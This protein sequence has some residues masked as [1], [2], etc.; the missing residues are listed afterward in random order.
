M[1]REFPRKVR[2]AESIKRLLAEPIAQVGRDA[3][4]GML[5]VTDVDVASDLSNAT[6][7]VS[8]FGAQVSNERILDALRDLRGDMRQRIARE[9]RMKKIPT[10]HFAVDE[11][12]ATG[13]RISELLAKRP[14]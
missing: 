9:L 6:V 11:S 14:D 3:G 1:P 5:T 2:V 13:A 4:L 7:Y 10:V 12:I 8:A